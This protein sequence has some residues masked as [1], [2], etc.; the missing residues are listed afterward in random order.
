MTNRV[1]LTGAFGSIGLR[2]LEQLLRAGHRVVC[3]DLKSAASEKAAAAFAGR[4]E[5]AWGDLRDDAVIE[6][7]LT[8]IDAV[9]HM[10]AI[11]P[12]LANDNPALATAVNLEA[13]RNLIRQMERSATAKRLVFASSMGLAGRDQSKRQ[14]PLRADEPPTPD[15]HYGQTKADCEDAIR[16]SQ[17]QWTLLRIAACPPEK[18]GSAKPG[19]MRLVFET[20]ATGR[21]EY[22]HPD[23]VAL[24]F[25]NAIACDAAIGKLLF[26]GGGAKCQTHA[27]PFFNQMFVAM[28]IGALPAE[29]F[30]PGSPYFFGDWLD[31]QESQA[32]LQFQR[33]TLEDYYRNIRHQFRLVRPV[34]RL[35]SP[36]VRR[37]ML[38]ES[39]Y[40]KA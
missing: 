6:R 14:P 31:T 30:R 40:M 8:G 28:G 24:A 9:V 4:V 34:L 22:V 12:P 16:N 33:H 2:V 38:R 36:L 26:V 29:A 25:A 39:P 11:I 7:A 32:L 27:E 3:L 37:R 23:D 1:L 21:V 5:L 19:E 17:T 10:A 13:T 35:L 15:D 20:S 18:L